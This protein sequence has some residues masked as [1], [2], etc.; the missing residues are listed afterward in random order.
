VIFARAQQTADA[1]NA[2]LLASPLAKQAAALQIRIAK[3][4]KKKTNKF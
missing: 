3:T 2:R 4:Q 1:A